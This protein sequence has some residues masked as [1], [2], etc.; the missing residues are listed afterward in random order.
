MSADLTLLVDASSLIYRALF[1]TPD[2]VT[3]RDGRP[4]NAAYGFLGMLAR[5]IAD[6]QVHFYMESLYSTFLVN[7]Q[8]GA[9]LLLR[10]P[11]RPEAW[12]SGPALSSWRA[13]TAGRRSAAT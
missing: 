9:R 13:G 11:D 10:N 8:T 1:S 2:T 12:R 4:I 5:L 7:E 3:G 6:G